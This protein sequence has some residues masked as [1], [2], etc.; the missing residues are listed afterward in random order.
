MVGYG[1]PLPELGLLLVPPLSEDEIK[2]KYLRELETG[3]AKAKAR[4]VGLIWET[5]KKSATVQIYLSKVMLGWNEKVGLPEKPEAPD[6]TE[7]K[8]AGTPSAREIE[9]AI[10]SFPG[11]QSRQS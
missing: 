5:A 6:N 11:P 3:P 4:L 8:P 9:A 2:V 1:M 7:T 10:L